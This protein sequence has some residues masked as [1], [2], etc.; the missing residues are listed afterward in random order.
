MRDDNNVEL[1]I[2]AARPV[3]SHTRIARAF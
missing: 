3:I 2:C 1:I